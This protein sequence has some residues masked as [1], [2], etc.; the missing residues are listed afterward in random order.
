M[1]GPACPCA[2][3]LN[4]PN[5]GVNRSFLLFPEQENETYETHRTKQNQTGTKQGTVT[6]FTIPSETG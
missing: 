4:G 6:N 5:A 1:P 2:D 3:A